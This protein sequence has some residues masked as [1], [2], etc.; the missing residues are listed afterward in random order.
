MSLRFFGFHDC[1]SEGK[2][3]FEILAQLK[4]MGVGRY[5]TKSEWMLKWPDQPSYLR[6]IK[7]FRPLKRLICL[8]ISGKTENGSLAPGGASLG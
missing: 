6:I 7:V 1:A 2:F 3:L 4:G 8:D 5:V